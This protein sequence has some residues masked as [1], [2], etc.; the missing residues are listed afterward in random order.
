MTEA[1]A[2]LLID[3]SEGDRA[4][5]H[6]LLDREFP[7]ATIAGVADPLA[8]AYSLGAEPPDVVVVAA[9]V[10]WANFAD[11][12]ASIKR[13]SPTT[14]IVLFGQEADILARVLAPGLACDGVVRKASAGFLALPAIVREVIQRKAGQ[15]AAAPAAEAAHEATPS[16]T[17]PRTDQDLRE[18]ALVFSHDFREPVQQIV[19]LA[20]RG[21]SANSPDAAVQSLRHVLE[22]ADR[23]STMLDGM[24]EYLTVTGRTASPASV[25]LNASLNQAL[26][27]LRGGIDD[28]Q[29][30]VRAAPLPVVSGDE[31]QLV[32]L[33]QNLVSNAIKFRSKERPVVTISCEP[34]GDTWHLAVRDNGIGIPEPLIE[35]I[36]DLGKRLHTREEYP[37]TGIGLALC[38]RIVERHGGRIWAES[39]DGHGSTFHLL[40]GRTSPD[41]ERGVRA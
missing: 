16:A 34:N 2:I 30:E 32:H 23:A 6:L 21:L 36:F 22:S 5:A 10:P 11:L 9:D 39:H 33:F 40:L 31:H 15:P 12:V 28:S 4:L 19:R 17:L 13:R 24:I 38:R 20:R 7:A 8:A 1:P 3:S 25:D 29:A 27:N 14:G 26:E 18:I 41:I 37:G 35:R